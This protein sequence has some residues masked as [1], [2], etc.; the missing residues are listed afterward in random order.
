M[1]G[2]RESTL[3]ALKCVWCESEDN[4]DFL[5]DYINVIILGICL[6][7][8][9]ILKATFKAK[10]VNRYLPLINGILGV[11]L[12]F[13]LNMSFTIEG[14]LVGLVSGLASCGAYDLVHQLKKKE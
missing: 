7:V 3:T 9:F 6:C 1:L 14:L 13:W 8:G 11:A 10:K 2:L 12:S 4:M 5:K